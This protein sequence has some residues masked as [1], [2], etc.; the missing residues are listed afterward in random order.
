MNIDYILNGNK[1]PKRKKQSKDPLID[2]F[3]MKPKKQ[4]KDNLMDLFIGQGHPRPGD[5]VT[6]SQ[7]KVLKSKNPMDLFGDWDGDRVINGLD[8]QPRNRK[9]HMAE[10]TEDQEH[11]INKI[12]WKKDQR[13]KKLGEGYFGRVY[14]VKDNPNYILKV[15]KDFEDH[16]K[17]YT[18]QIH[19]IDREYYKYDNYLR[20]EP[21]VIPTERVKQGLLRPKLKIINEGMNKTN[22][23][24]YGSSKKIKPK[25]TYKEAQKI[26]RQIN[27]FTNKNI[28][29][30]DEI[31]VGRDK[32]NNVFIYD[33]GEFSKQQGYRAPAARNNNRDYKKHFLNEV[34]RLEVLDFDSDAESDL[35]I[36]QINNPDQ[37][38]Y[39]INVKT[40]VAKQ[41]R[42]NL[43]PNQGMSEKR[44][45]DLKWTK[46]KFDKNEM[47]PI[48]VDENQFKSGVLGDGRHRI[49]AAQRLDRDKIKVRVCPDQ[50]VRDEY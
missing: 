19:N 4:K 41:M 16:P 18:G 33:L 24:T 35:A 31:Q 22:Y 46:N 2:L 13:G 48:E 40:K 29:V 44:R 11:E 36:Q 43:Y 32:N 30:G 1:K 28:D 45:R 37:E 14:E 15:D 49:I 10:F 20:K 6:K 3:S 27:N 34:N 38:Y 12:N 23:K 39:D 50:V 25:L 47:E 9:K 42:Q 17:S 8:C 26:S 5:R 21:L 7:R